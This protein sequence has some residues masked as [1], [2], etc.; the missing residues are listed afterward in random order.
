MATKLFLF[1]SLLLL[2]VSCSRPGIEN[3]DR[4]TAKGLNLNGNIKH[5][6]EETNDDNTIWDIEFVD[7]RILTVHRNAV[8]RPDNYP[9]LFAYQDSI[10]TQITSAGVVTTPEDFEFYFK[11]RFPLYGFQDADT[12]VKNDHGD[13]ARVVEHDGAAYR[14]EY[15]YDSHGNWITRDLYYQDSDQSG[16][17]TKRTILYSYVVTPREVETWHHE[18]D[19]IFSAAKLRNEPLLSIDTTIQH[20]RAKMKSL[21]KLA[22]QKYDELVATEARV[23]TL[24]KKFYTQYGYDNLAPELRRIR[25]KIRMLGG[26]AQAQRI[27]WSEARIYLPWLISGEKTVRSLQEPFP[28]RYLLT[29]TEELISLIKRNE[30]QYASFNANPEATDATIDRAESEVQFEVK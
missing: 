16:E 7:N 20:D 18:L 26:L 9:Y 24:L 11:L 21:N 2:I 23:D 12:L 19:S 5:V 10:L 3:P 28:D 29:L 8:G 15:T 22:N 6:T 14:I 27:L 30:R 13:V 1:L 17:Q 4:F 25:S